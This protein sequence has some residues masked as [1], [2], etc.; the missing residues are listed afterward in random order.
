MP[1]G[2]LVG[3][4]FGWWQAAEREGGSGGFDEGLKRDEG[5]RRGRTDRHGTVEVMFQRGE[6]AKT[7]GGN[8]EFVSFLKKQPT[9]WRF[10]HVDDGCRWLEGSKY[11]H[12]VS[13]FL[14]STTKF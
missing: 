3:F 12:V 6:K 14:H 4:P 7:T 13:N 9:G 11:R 10:T 8:T 1:Q 2:R 5:D